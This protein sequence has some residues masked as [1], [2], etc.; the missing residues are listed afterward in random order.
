MLECMQVQLH[1][2]IYIYMYIYVFI[3][4]YI[5]LYIYIYVHIYIHICIYIYIFTYIYIYIYIYI[6]RH[7][8]KRIKTNCSTVPTWANTVCTCGKDTVQGPSQYTQITSNQF[9]PMEKQKG[10]SSGLHP[11][12]RQPSFPLD[13]IPF[14]EQV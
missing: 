10:S 4:I 7:N 5:F 3:C 11:Q 1:I 12:K 6:I 8:K 9:A 13:S 2:Y 14:G